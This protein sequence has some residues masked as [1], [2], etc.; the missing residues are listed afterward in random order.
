MNLAWKEI[1]K[2]QVRLLILGSIIFLVSLLT[3]MIS[4][5]A[6]A[7]SQ[8]NAALIMDLP[9]GQFTMQADA[10][11]NDMYNLSK[12]DSAVQNNLLSK[13]KDAVAFSI[14]LVF[15]Q[16]EEDQQQSIAFVTSTE[17]I[18]FEQVK[19]GELILDSSLQEKGIQV[20]EPLTNNQLDGSFIVKGFVDQKTF[21]HAPVA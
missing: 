15:L 10:D 7:L 3:F 18:L 21:T 8:D 12:I 16:N 14:Q 11:A 6:N 19:H 5:L 2:N 9:E 4:G 17:S 1:K 13:E 20:G